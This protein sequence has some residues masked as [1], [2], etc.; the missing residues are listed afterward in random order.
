MANQFKTISMEF[1]FI[2]IIIFFDCLVVGGCC[3]AKNK[4]KKKTTTKKRKKSEMIY[5]MYHCMYNVGL[6]YVM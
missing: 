3:C 1:H 2:Y 4:H 6:F 5:K